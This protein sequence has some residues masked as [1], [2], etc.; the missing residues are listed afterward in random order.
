MSEKG[1]KNESREKYISQ[2]P[3]VTFLLVKTL[4]AASNFN[5]T[6]KF[7]QHFKYLKKYLYIVLTSRKF[8]GLEKQKQSI[9]NCFVNLIQTFRFLYPFAFLPKVVTQLK[10][11]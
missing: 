5:V 11:I 8:M 10:P 3:N 7:C 2:T 6:G 4:L 1:M 9:I